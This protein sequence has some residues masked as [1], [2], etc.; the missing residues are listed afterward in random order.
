MLLSIDMHWM[1]SARSF[2]AVGL[3]LLVF[4]AKL[5]GRTFGLK[6]SSPSLST[7]PWHKM[8]S[9]FSEQL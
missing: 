3:T 1:I 6:S 5:Q 4:L 9:A 2:A 7:R 8:A